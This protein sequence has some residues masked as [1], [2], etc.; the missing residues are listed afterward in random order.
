M[1]IVSLLPSATEILCALGLESQLVAVS[2]AC[3]YPP[4]VSELPKATRTVIDTNQSSDAID[5]QVRAHLSENA[6]LYTL[7][8]K[9]LEQLAPDLIVTQ[10]LCDVCA[11]SATEVNRLASRLTGSPR[12]LNL[13]PVSLADVFATVALVGKACGVE[14]AAAELQGQM[15]HRIANIEDR[16][17]KTAH[18]P[19]V[20]FLEWLD[21]LFNGG[22]WNGELIKLAGGID[23]LNGFGQASRTLN[24]A[25]LIAAQPELLFVACCGYST[26]RA[27]EDLRLAQARPGWADLP[28]VKLGRVFVADGNHYFNRPGPR[29]VESL[30]ILAA[31][32]HSE[33]DW[34]PSGVPAAKRFSGEQKTWP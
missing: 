7:E 24:F 27:L 20:A 17:T 5:R 18:K 11:V 33:P 2:H 25:E 14:L 21:P 28:C 8:E 12:V 10:A 4:A 6:A 1:K 29:L 16:V 30:E 19:R 32:L 3:D 22:H 23:V 26:E 31:A 9:K 15:Q 13:E 34:V